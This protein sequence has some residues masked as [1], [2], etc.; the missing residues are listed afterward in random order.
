MDG[1]VRAGSESNEGARALGNLLVETSTLRVLSVRGV[2]E[3]NMAIKL[4]LVVEG[5]HENK[6]LRRLCLDGNSCGDEG[7]MALCRAL[8]ENKTLRAVTLQRN[9]LTFA[10]L[11]S[12][13]HILNVNSTLLDMG[14][15]SM[16]VGEHD[17]DKTTALAEQIM[18]RL[19]MNREGYSV[20]AV[21][22]MTAG[23]IIIGEDVGPRGGGGGGSG[24]GG[25][26]SS[27]SG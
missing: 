26:G 17:S 13:R 6:S 12:L 22:A 1:N 2:P 8:K 14:N 25:A 5:L 18:D 3:T 20:E 9:N 15:L 27:G 23:K 16:P 11:R 21:A 10:G 24:G 19:E 7:V 4:A